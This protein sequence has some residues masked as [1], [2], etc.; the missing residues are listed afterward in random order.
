MALTEDVRYAYK[1]EWSDKVTGVVWDYQ[2]NLFPE[3]GEIE[4]VRYVNSTIEE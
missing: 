3:S 2:L 1:V 4:M